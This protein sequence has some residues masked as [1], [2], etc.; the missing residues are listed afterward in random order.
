MSAS[1]PSVPLSV[2]Q[3]IIMTV[4]ETYTLNHYGKPLVCV[5]VGARRIA[6]IA[7]CDFMREG[8]V[9]AEAVVGACVRGF[10]GDVGVVGGHYLYPR[11]KV[12]TAK[13]WR[14]GCESRD[15]V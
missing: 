15:P 12:V 8:I 10:G 5:G 2:T 14:Y 13:P 7:F 9:F 1:V 3:G 4:E 11:V 6:P